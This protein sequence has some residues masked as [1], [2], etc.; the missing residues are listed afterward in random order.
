M[1]GTGVKILADGGDI[2]AQTANNTEVGAEVMVVVDPVE[3]FAC[4]PIIS[5]IMDFS[6]SPVVIAII[7]LMVVPVVVG[8]LP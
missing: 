2:P 3:R 7:P 8:G 5:L 4:L 1:I 6:L